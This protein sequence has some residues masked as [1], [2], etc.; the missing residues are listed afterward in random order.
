MVDI[1]ILTMV[2]K[3][4]NIPGGA[5]PCMFLDVFLSRGPTSFNMLVIDGIFSSLAASMADTQK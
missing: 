4:A 5:P 2:Y 1:S 3:P